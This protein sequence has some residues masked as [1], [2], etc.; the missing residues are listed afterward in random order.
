MAALFKFDFNPELYA[1]WQAWPYLFLMPAS[2]CGLVLIWS[3][4]IPLVDFEAHQRVPHVGC[5]HPNAGWWPHPPGWTTEGGSDAGHEARRWQH[6]SA[7]STPKEAQMTLIWSTQP[8]SNAGLARQR[9][10][11]N[12]V[13]ASGRSHL[14]MPR[15][16]LLGLV[17]RHWSL[18]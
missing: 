7:S 8:S 11:R 5:S 2:A 3:L 4:I 15:C 17:I 16:R 9:L 10:E 6:E 14:L 1:S 13:L 12:H 18:A